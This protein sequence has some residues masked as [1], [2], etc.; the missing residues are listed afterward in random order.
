[1]D[2]LEICSSTT[3]Q[4]FRSPQLIRLPYI[5]FVLTFPY[6]IFLLMLSKVIIVISTSFLGAFW[7][8]NGIDYYVENSKALYYSVNILHGMLSKS[9]R[10]YKRKIEEGKIWNHYKLLFEVFKFV[11]ISTY[12]TW[13]SFPWVA[14]SWETHL[15]RW[16]ANAMWWFY[17]LKI[18]GSTECNLHF[19]YH[20]HTGPH[21]CCSL[22]W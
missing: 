9:L 7:S 16:A 3:A 11:H 1:M 18:S 14:Y 10:S 6:A 19:S 13:I 12:V 17:C 20:G 5:Y 21:P 8:I 2:L 15:N 22:T 4:N